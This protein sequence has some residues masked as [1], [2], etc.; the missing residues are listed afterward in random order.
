MKPIILVAIIAMASLYVYKHFAVPQP[1]KGA[2]F[3]KTTLI[4]N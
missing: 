2:A 4:K 1:Q 3:S